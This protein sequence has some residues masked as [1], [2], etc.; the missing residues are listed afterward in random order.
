MKKEI[1]GYKGYFVDE[2]GNIYGKR[3]EVLTPVFQKKTGYNRISLVKDGTTHNFS[4]HR[5]VAEA[6]IENPL[7]LPQVNHKNGIKTD[8]R[9]ENLEWVSK[10]NN[11]LH[12]IHIL[13]KGLDGEGNPRHKL[14]EKDVV[15]I[16][17]RAIKGE[18]V[19]IVAKDYNITPATVCDIKAGRS[20]YKVTGAPR[21]RKYNRWNTAY[22]SITASQL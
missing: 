22:Q 21:N 19:S 4:I 13:G 1:E 17:E 6:F 2:K 11:Q 14:T 7:N 18:S 10:S 16:Y 15:S 3:K 12:R 9:V 5:I 8:N 20:W